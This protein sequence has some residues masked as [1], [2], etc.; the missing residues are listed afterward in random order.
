[1]F[2]EDAENIVLKKFAVKEFEEK[3]EHI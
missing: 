1:M 2:S 3:L